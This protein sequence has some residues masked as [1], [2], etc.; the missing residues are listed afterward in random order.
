MEGENL[1][2]D[3]RMAAVG[4]ADSI[5]GFLALGVEIFPVTSSEEA[6]TRL[7]GLTEENEYGI[8][9]VTETV[10]QQVMETITTLS[11]RALPSIV[12][13]P[14]N[15]GAHGFALERIRTIVERAVGADILTG[16]EGR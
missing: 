16:K 2:A 10:A 14:S 12:L 6:A 13:I 11:E 8:I 7:K 5:I 15:R 3:Y 1:M 9:F 4:E